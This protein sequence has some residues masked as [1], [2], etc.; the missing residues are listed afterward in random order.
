VVEKGG[1]GEKDVVLGF[2]QVDGKGLLSPRE[3][4]AYRG[5]RCTPIILGFPQRTCPDFCCLKLANNLV[6][7]RKL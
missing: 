5:V 3:M 1:G 4:I 7:T 6:K 2:V